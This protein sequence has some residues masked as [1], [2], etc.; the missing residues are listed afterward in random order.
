MT[1]VS[2]RS[3][4]ILPFVCLINVIECCS[5][6]SFVIIMKKWQKCDINY[7]FC[8]ENAFAKNEIYIFINRLSELTYIITT[9]QQ[10]VPN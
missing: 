3:S 2:F 5:V 10:R 1:S 9:T 8:C 7:I 6:I 4:H